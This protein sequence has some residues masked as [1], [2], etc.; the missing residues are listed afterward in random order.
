MDD[1]A[2]LQRFLIMGQGLPCIRNYCDTSEQ[3][4]LTVS[5]TKPSK[6]MDSIA[7]LLLNSS[8]GDH[9]AAPPIVTNLSK[10]M[11]SLGK[12]AGVMKRTQ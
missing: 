5:V 12:A 7:A 6:T 2:D 8:E 1:S 9:R 10:L 4:T 3:A 11:R